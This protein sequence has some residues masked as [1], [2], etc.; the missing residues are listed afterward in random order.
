MIYDEPRS[1]EVQRS[2]LSRRAFHLFASATERCEK[3]TIRPSPRSRHEK[4][5]G[6]DT[7][8]E[9]PDEHSP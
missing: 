8:Q 7:D 5:L 1:S 6:V 4:R 3:G 9:A 2:Q